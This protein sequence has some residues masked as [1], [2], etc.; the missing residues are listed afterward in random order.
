MSINRADVML[1]SKESEVN[2]S[3]QCLRADEEGVASG[4]RIVALV[5]PGDHCPNQL[6]QD[7]PFTATQVRETRCSS[8]QKRSER[9]PEVLAAR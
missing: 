9:G 7:R 8:S 1:G 6:V 4:E 3:A 5:R 2:E